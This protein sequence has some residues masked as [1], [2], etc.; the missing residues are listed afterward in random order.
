[1]FVRKLEYRVRK[2]R[3]N[4]GKMQETSSRLMEESKQAYRLSRYT[5]GDSVAI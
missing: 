4:Y 5:G 2:H 1:M 3:N